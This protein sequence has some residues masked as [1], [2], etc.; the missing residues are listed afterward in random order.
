M[1]PLSGDARN[2]TYLEGLRARRLE[3]R[4]RE[5]GQ[6]MSAK[7]PDVS[8]SVDPCAWQAWLLEHHGQL[9]RRGHVPDAYLSDDDEDGP[10]V[11]E[12]EEEEEW[13]QKPDGAEAVTRRRQSRKEEKERTRAEMKAQTHPFRSGWACKLRGLEEWEQELRRDK[14]REL[15]NDARLANVTLTPAL[16]R[17]LPLMGRKPPASAAGEGRSGAPSSRRL[18]RVTAEG[19]QRQLDLAETGDAMRLR[20]AGG[21]DVGVASASCPGLLQRQVRGAGREWGRAWLREGVGAWLRLRGGAGRGALDGWEEGEEGRAD[22]PMSRGSQ[23]RVQQI[24]EELARQARAEGK[25][26]EFFLESDEWDEKTRRVMA[27]LRDF[28]TP[29]YTLPKQQRV[30]LARDLTD[31]VR[32]S[33]VPE[34]VVLRVSACLRAVEEGLASKRGA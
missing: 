27:A 14:I 12:E 6:D 22:A 31:L 29:L 1:D 19:F 21:G 8:R 28:E 2:L 20:G 3:K 5:R 10:G 32:G 13:S 11:E 34:W 25:Y 16:R 24:E 26:D 4:A 9:A 15:Q 23:E 30:D 7:P 18:P 17:M 33:T